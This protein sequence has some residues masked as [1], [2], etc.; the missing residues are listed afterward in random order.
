MQSTKL[1]TGKFVSYTIR[2]NGKV[3]EQ[4]YA[5]RSIQIYHAIN[6]IGKAEIAIYCGDMPNSNVPESE[7]EYF[8]PGTAIDILLGYDCNDKPVFSG[9]VT[10]QRIKLPRS[11]TEKMLLIVECKNNAIKTTFQR[12]NKVFLEKTDSDVISEVLTS[13][14]ISVSVDSTT[15]KHGQLVQYYCSDWD[16]VLSRADACG[17][18]V[19]TSGNKVK[20]FKPEVGAKPVF[21]VKYGLDILSFDGEL[22]AEA[23]TTAAECVGWNPTDQSL[24]VEHVNAPAT[25]SQGNIAIR[26]MSQN[27]GC[28][29]IYFQNDGCYDSSLL[30]DWGTSQ[31]LKNGLARYQGSFSICGCEEVVPGCIV[32]LEGMGERFNGNVFVG[33]VTHTYKPGQWITEVG[34]GINPANITQKAD[35]ISPSA[36]GFLPGI[37]GLHIGIVQQ[38]N[39]DPN[40]D[41]RIRVK[42]PLL[43]NK[44][45]VVWARLVQ[46][47]ASSGSGCHFVPSVGD[48]VIL[49]FINN[50]PNTAII[51]GA[52]FSGKHPAMFD[53]DDKNYKRAIITPES[54]TILLDDEK[55]GVL[56][57]TPG[58]NTIEVCDKDKKITL[59]DQNGN[60]VVLEDGGITLVADKKVTIDAADIE[61]KGKSSVKIACQGDIK[62]EGMNIE[63][64]AKANV[65]I[66]SSVATEVSS[67]LNTTIKGVLVKIN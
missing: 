27:T 19:S 15:A 62:T 39:G 64:N 59:K 31:L 41:F 60:S 14:G 21:S 32:K 57:S 10:S 11:I 30:K 63:T 7:S 67:S 9:I 40:S 25:N 28:E 66:C 22:Q 36:S 54:L 49:G 65:K 29:K 38:L 1:N 42:I 61:L 12:K 53:Y 17:L 16:F 13:S 34:M 3:I 4:T 52:L 58:G 50:D 2:C 37:E 51:L 23:Q 44:D 20:V 45:N 35:V 26:E 43:N 5:V 33:S 55:K 56:I 46:F 48:E 6:R 18:F 24:V 8:V 47:A